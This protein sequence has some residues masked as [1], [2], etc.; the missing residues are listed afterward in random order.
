M[1]AEPRRV[2]PARGPGAAWRTRRRVRQALVGAHA[3]PLSAAELRV[4]SQNGED[5]VL[6]AILER[7]GARSRFFVEFG[8][9]PGEEANC[10]LLARCYGWSGLM[11]EADDDGYR[12]LQAAYQ[13]T[14]VRT[15][16]RRVT[17]GNVESLFAEAGVPRDLD[18]LSIDID[19]NDYHVWEAV[20][21]YSPRIVVVEYNGN[22]PLDSRLVMPRDDEHAWDGT[23][24][25]GASLG[26]LRELA[27]RKGYRLVHTDR[28]G[29][30]AFFVA[31]ADA[32]AGRFDSRT[33]ALH[34]A[35]YFGQGI[36]LPEDPQGRL[37]HDLE[38]GRLVPAPRGSGE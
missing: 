24:Y 8:V 2:R 35:N 7:I 26:A 11:I 23:D 21:A 31:S 17:P 19:G 6:Q 16:H 22:L 9:G 20:Q 5:G 32:Q 10:V 12:Q 14:G 30:N 33:A 38:S 4:F 28:T 13:G 25:F 18:L 27:G 1:H 34:R 15:L 37:W 36:R 29:A 3:Q